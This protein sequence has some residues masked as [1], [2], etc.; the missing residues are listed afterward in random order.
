[1]MFVNV[2]SKSA[3]LGMAWM[4]GCLYTDLQGVEEPSKDKRMYILLSSSRRWPCQKGGRSGWQAWKVTLA[5]VFCTCQQE[6]KLEG[7]E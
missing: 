2:M 5:T 7:S 6:E 1:M 3:S 4:G